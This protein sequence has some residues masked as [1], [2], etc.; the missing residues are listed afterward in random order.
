MSNPSPT[1]PR[2]RI[3]PPVFFTSVALVLVFVLGAVI[4][5]DASARLF[6]AVQGWVTHGGGWLYVLAVAG[7]LVFVV[8]VAASRDGAIKLGPE[9]REPDYSYT[10]W[11]AMLF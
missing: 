10:A 11:F 5:P 7:F 1:L 8:G 6:V 2:Y 9:H 3:N 4:W